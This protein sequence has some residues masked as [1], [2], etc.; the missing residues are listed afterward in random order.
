M[1]E[2]ISMGRET[3]QLPVGYDLKGFKMKSL[4]PIHQKSMLQFLYSTMRKLPFVLNALLVPKKVKAK[5]I[6]LQMLTG[7]MASINHYHLI[8]E[9]SSAAFSIIAS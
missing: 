5:P 8:P 7:G 2:E 6:I 4:L 1:Q 3:E 9:W